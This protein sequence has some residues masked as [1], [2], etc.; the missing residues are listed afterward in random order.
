MKTEVID[1]IPVNV[2]HRDVRRTTIRVRP[3]K[4]GPKPKRR[5]SKNRKLTPKERGELTIQ[6]R[7]AL[8]NYFQGGVSKQ[9]AGEA[10]GYSPSCASARVTNALE[11]LAGNEAFQKAMKAEGIDNE[12]LAKV[13]KEGLK[14]E[15]PFKRGR[16]DWHAIH[17]FFQDALKVKNAF[18]PTR[19]QQEGTHRH[20]HV[21]MTQSDAEAVNRYNRLREAEVA[22]GS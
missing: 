4:P 19:V 6:Q 21:H 18:P 20:V 12:S 3:R 2:T 1:G 15:H 22:D 16:K 17:K 13:L 9:Q 11:T 14:A 8:S 5:V 10:A 7:T